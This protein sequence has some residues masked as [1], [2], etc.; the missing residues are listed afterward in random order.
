MAIIWQ[1]VQ[2]DLPLLL[3]ATSEILARI[4]REKK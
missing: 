1:V 4:N 3:K 2:D